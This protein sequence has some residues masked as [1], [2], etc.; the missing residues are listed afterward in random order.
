MS[1]ANFKS[2]VNFGSGKTPRDSIIRIFIFSTP[3]NHSFYNSNSGLWIFLASEWY[4]SHNIFSGVPSTLLACFP[5]IL[6]LSFCVSLLFRGPKRLNLQALHVISQ[7]GHRVAHEGAT[8]AHSTVGFWR[9]LA[10][11]LVGVF[12]K[13]SPQ[14]CAYDIY[15]IYTHTHMLLKCIHYFIYIQAHKR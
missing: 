2:I 4:V 15:M 13:I 12:K 5:H 6:L 3:V 8:V 11:Y 10:G 9:I 7:R 1:C 14:M